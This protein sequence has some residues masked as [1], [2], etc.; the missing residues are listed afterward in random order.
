VRHTPT[1][2]YWCDIYRHKDGR[3]QQIGEPCDVC[4]GTGADRLGGPC[5]HAIYDGEVG[6]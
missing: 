6:E 1:S 5:R 3:R 2:C 4:G